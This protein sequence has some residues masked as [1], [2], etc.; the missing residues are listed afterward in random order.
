MFCLAGPPQV[1]GICGQHTTAGV[2]TTLFDMDSLVTLKDLLDKGAIHFATE[3]STFAIGKFGDGRS[4]AFPVLLLGS[5][6]ASNPEQQKAIIEQVSLE[7]KVLTRRTT[8]TQAL[9]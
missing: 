3:G 1:L 8:N 4:A 2:D 6:K 9:K 7:A 5:C